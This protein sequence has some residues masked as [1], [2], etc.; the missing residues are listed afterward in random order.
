MTVLRVYPLPRR[1]IFTLRNL[2]ITGRESERG[3]DAGGT[4][5][6]FGTGDLVKCGVVHPATE[7]VSFAA[8]TA[9]VRSDCKRLALCPA[10]IRRRMSRCPSGGTGGHSD[11]IG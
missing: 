6:R 9:T 8:L 11:A 5:P 4:A 3:G 10:T 2:H 7:T 1:H